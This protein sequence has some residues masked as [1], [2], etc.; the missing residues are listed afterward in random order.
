MPCATSSRRASPSS[1]P[2]TAPPRSSTSTRARSSPWLRCRTSTPTS[3]P[4]RSIP[5]RINRLSVGVYEMGSTFKALSIA[6]GLR[7][8]ARSRC[9]RSSTR[10]TS[11][12]Y[13]RFTIHDFHAERTACSRSPRCSIIPRTSARRSIAMMVGIEGHQAFLRKMGQLTR[14]RTELPESRGA[15]DPEALGHAE[16]DHD[17]L[18]PGH[19]R[20]A[21]AV[22]D[23]GR[24]PRQ[25]RHP[26]EADLLEAHRIEDAQ[27]RRAARGPSRS[28]GERSAT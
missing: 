1:T 2:R 22:A 25:R 26:C 28:V 13:G 19:Q 24:R 18:R 20:R 23:G 27:S 14:L 7:G 4:K 17:R 5:N 9:A 6:M 15:A 3:R 16:H 12:Q 21:A 10:A 11:L 8:P